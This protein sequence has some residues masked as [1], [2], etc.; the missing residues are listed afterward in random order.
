MKRSLSLSAVTVCALAIAVGC[1][2]HTSQPSSPSGIDPS[3]VETT[4]EGSALKASA[5][6]LQSP[7][8]GVQLPVNEPVQLV[9]GNSTTAFAAVPLSY[10]FELTDAGGNVVENVVVEGGS[11]ST[12]Y[13]VTTGLEGEQTYQWRARAEYQGVGGPWSGR[14]AFVSPVSEGYIRGSELYDPLVNG[15][16][17]GTVHGPVTF[18]PGVGARLESDESYIEYGLPET[19]V[20]GE[21]SA[22]VSGLGV[23]SR[24]EDPKWRVLTMREGYS[25]I[26]DNEYRMSIDKRGNGAVAWRFITGNNRPGR[27]IET[28][29][30]ERVALP[31][32]EDLTYLVRASWGG[33]VFRV[34]YVEGGVDGNAIYDLAKGYQREYTPFPHMVYAGSPYQPG[35]RG[36][37]STVA[38][39]IIRQIW[40]SPNP[41]PAYANK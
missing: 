3:L 8:N 2:K 12:V 27:Y 41:R 22:L 4:A 33:G 37:P 11:G 19:L 23:I 38:G 24:N 14:Q 10:R 18:I 35:D 7:I 9:I 1:S 34:Q 29:G 5:P 32:H 6:T 39:M 20:A 36:E 17:V 15:K 28:V 13:T 26:N 21:Y 25:A 30:R 16:T 40:V 31:F